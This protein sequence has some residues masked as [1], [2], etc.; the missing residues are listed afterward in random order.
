MLS[1]LLAIYVL[2]VL[3]YSLAI[4]MALLLVIGITKGVRALVRRACAHRLAAAAYP[5]QVSVPVL[6]DLRRPPR[7]RHR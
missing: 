6:L 2:I 3:G 5:E 4:L 7:G 1:L